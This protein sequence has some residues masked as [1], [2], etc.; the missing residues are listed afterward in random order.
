[1]YMG[2]ASKPKDGALD[3]AL[4]FEGGDN[5]F[6]GTVGGLFLNNGSPRRG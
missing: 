2:M 4:Y 5:Y 1:M 6:L 3:R